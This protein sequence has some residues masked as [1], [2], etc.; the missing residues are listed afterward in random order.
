VKVNTTL[1]VFFDVS[2]LKEKVGKLFKLKRIYLISCFLIL[3]FSIKAQ[4]SFFCTFMLY[5]NS[6]SQYDL[7]SALRFNPRP[8]RV[9]F[10]A[11]GEDGTVN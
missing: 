5:Y 2:I 3:F 7:N 10:G 9:S 1:D 6:I 8:T 4:F 11:M